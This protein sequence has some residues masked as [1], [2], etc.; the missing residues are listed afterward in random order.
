MDRSKVTDDNKSQG[1]KPGVALINTS[2]KKVC[3]KK[4]NTKLPKQ[5][6]PQITKLKLT[7]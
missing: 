4:K 1:D 7:K 6:S 5:L 2:E 3:Q